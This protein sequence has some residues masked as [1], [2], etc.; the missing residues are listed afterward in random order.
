MLILF[1]MSIKLIWVVY[2]LLE[3]LVLFKKRVECNLFIAQTG[4]TI[5][6]L[7]QL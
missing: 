3:I 6:V 5:G 4:R 1:S 2:Y 7:F